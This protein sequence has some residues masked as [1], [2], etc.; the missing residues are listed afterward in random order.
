MLWAHELAHVEQFR[1]GS[2]AFSLRYVR[3]WRKLECEAD[4]RAIL[5]SQTHQIGNQDP[6]PGS[7]QPDP[8]CLKEVTENRDVGIPVLRA[9]STD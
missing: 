9:N 1:A 7:Y 4:R 2:A 8:I 5:W 3:N 6:A